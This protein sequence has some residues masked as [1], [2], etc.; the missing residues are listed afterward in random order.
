M[1]P[2]APISPLP[3]VVHRDTRGRVRCAAE[4]T[5]DRSEFSGHLTTDHRCAVQPSVPE[6]LTEQTVRGHLSTCERCVLCTSVAP[7]P[8]NWCAETHMKGCATQRNA[9]LTDQTAQGIY[10][11][12][13]RCAVQ[14]SEPQRHCIKRGHRGGARRTSG[15]DVCCEPQCHRVCC[16]P[17]CR[18]SRTWGTETHTEAM[19]AVHRS[20]PAQLTEQTT[21]GT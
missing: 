18:R 16:A 3:H 8:Q 13:Q 4:R 11:P 7:L 10:T 9:Q 19:C 1:H 2:T 5:I 17:Q 14:R 21:E 12:D 15:S 20:V 6:Q